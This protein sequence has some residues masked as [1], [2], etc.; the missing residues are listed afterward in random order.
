MLEEVVTRRPRF[1]E[2]VPKAFRGVDLDI[3]QTGPA[4]GPLWSITQA[5]SSDLA[6]MAGQMAAP[7]AA[8]L[9]TKS[10]TIFVL[11]QDG[12]WLINGCRVHSG[13]GAFFARGADVDVASAGPCSWYA[14]Q[15]SEDL[16]L[17]HVIAMNLKPLSPGQAVRALGKVCMSQS[18]VPPVAPSS[19]WTTAAEEES[20]ARLAALLAAQ[21]GPLLA[22]AIGEAGCPLR[23]GHERIA[24]QAMNYLRERK[25]SAVDTME[26]CKTLRVSER[27]L[28]EAFL[29]VY[30]VT[31][32]K[33]LRL[34]R[35]HQARMALMSANTTVTAVAS[36]LDF[37]DFGRFA[38]SYRE[39]FGEPPSSTLRHR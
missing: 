4:D 38:R 26:L 16:L 3:W 23:S 9:N 27:W 28:R 24:R 2:E 36:S 34:R 7:Y 39:L 6:M 22:K 13:E 5:R 18:H 35:L 19:P 20:R 12:P 37:H 1:I 15:F 14:V 30:G 8:T 25:D 32:T 29:R 21:A 11:Q 31:A 10:A 33:L 17:R